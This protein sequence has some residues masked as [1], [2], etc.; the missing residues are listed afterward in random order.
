MPQ[1]SEV[2]FLPRLFSSVEQR[3][4][5]QRDGIFC[6]DTKSSSTET[7]FGKTTSHLA[8]DGVCVSKIVNEACCSLKPGFSLAILRR[9]LNLN[10]HGN[11]IK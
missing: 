4:S 11:L 9:G 5:T 10:V 2:T 7:A 3:T 8:L 6:T 1:D